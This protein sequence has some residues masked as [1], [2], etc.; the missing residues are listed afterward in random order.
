MN[1]G[2]ATLPV[3]HLVRYLIVSLALGVAWLLVIPGLLFNFS[4][5]EKTGYRKVDLLTVLL[6]PIIG[7]FIAIR[8]QWR[9]VAASRYWA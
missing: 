1:N 9:Y 2:F 8:T 4:I 7:P 6:V 5:L 3:P